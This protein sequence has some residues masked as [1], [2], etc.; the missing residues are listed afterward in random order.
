MRIWPFSRGILKNSHAPPPPPPPP[1]F[2]S[3]EADV[4]WTDVSQDYRNQNSLVEGLIKQ[5]SSA[6]QCDSSP[7]SSQ[8]SAKG[9]RL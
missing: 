2:L 7:P 6:D 8:W 9:V 1:P 3:D 4:D 5:T